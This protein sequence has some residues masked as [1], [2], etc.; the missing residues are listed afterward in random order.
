MENKG[1]VLVD[2][3]PIRHWGGFDAILGDE[4]KT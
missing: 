1:D 3:V 4:I 2:V